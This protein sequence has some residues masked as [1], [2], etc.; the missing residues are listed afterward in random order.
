MKV[1]I[2]GIHANLRFSSAHMIPGHQFCG[3]IHGHSYHVDVQVDGE[4]CGE[5]GF[6]VDF[7]KVK[8]LMRDLCAELDH[9]V[10]IPLQ[11]DDI[12]FN[13]MEGSVDFSIGA[14]GYSLPLEDCCL[15]PLKSTSA[16]ELAEYFAVKLY[17]SLK[18]NENE[19]EIK[20]GSVQVCVNE[21][22]GQGAY[23]EI[24]D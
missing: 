7:K 19:S 17:K 10:L 14:K 5:F 6:V 22:I 4:R 12:R 9:K 3:G 1:V 15:L 16:E 18:K 23:F 11:S 2:N 24:K 21:G 8:D 13:N 20:I